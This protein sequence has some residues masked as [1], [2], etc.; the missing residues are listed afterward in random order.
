MKALMTGQEDSAGQNDSRISLVDQYVLSR[1]PFA[2]IQRLATISESIER[3]PYRD[4]RSMKRQGK[5]LPHF[6]RGLRR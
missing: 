1:D 3:R 5:Q 4:A 2:R 6:N